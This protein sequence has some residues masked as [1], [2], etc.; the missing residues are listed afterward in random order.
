M[1]NYNSIQLGNA[2]DELN[3]SLDT[4]VK[5]YVEY[6][7]KN[8]QDNGQKASDSQRILNNTML[9]FLSVVLIHLFFSW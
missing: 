7:N 6:N 1:G 5:T 9:L 8:P 2:R 4:F 3:K